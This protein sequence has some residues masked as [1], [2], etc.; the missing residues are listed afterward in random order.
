MIMK[1]LVKAQLRLNQGIS[2]I[3][4]KDKKE[5]KRSEEEEEKFL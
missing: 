4:L 3:R 2:D 5:L 1:I